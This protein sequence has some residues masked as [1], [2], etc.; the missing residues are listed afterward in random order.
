MKVLTTLAKGFAS[1]RVDNGGE[2][3]ECGGERAAVNESNIGRRQDKMTLVA[4]FA[5]AKI[6]CS[7]NES[8]LVLFL[9]AAGTLFGRTVGRSVGESWRLAMM[10]LE[11]GG[12]VLAMSS[13]SGMT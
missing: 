9:Q 3:T 13:S 5:T 10:V 11:S 1:W 6:L 7:F 12:R 8:K 4:K 2:G